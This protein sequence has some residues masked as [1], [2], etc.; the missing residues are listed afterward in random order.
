MLP[1]FT[2]HLYNPRN[3]LKSMALLVE[4]LASG[5]DPTRRVTFRRTAHGSRERPTNF[6][7]VRPAVLLALRRAAAS[8]LIRRSHQTQVVAGYG[9]ED[10]F[11]HSNPMTPC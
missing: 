1:I 9:W 8:A 7:P 3:V 10:A 2:F 6:S 5:D 11:P 4:P